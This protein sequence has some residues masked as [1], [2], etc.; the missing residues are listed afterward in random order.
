MEFPDV[1]LEAHTG[2][3]A[4]SCAEGSY[5]LNDR[6]VVQILRWLRSADEHA[7]RALELI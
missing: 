6:K 3:V 5:V 2:G 7:D 4:G 1:E